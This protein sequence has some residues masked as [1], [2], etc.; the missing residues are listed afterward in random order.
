MLALFAGS[1]VVWAGFLLRYQWRLDRL[2]GEAVSSGTQPSQELFGTLRK[3]YAWD[4]I[5]TVLPLVSLYLIVLKP[6]LW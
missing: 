4:I 1:G 3:W 5:A 6:H 2:S